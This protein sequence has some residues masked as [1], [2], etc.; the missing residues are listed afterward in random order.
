MKIVHM[1]LSCFFVD[2]YSYQENEI[3][4]TN[5]DDGHE[6][7]VIASTETFGK[8]GK[9][10]YLQPSEY[11]GSEGAKIIR[12]PYKKFLPHFFMR[13][14]RC[15]PRVF[16]ILNDIRPDVILFHGLCGWELITVNKYKKKNSLVKLYVD[17]H[18]DFNN[19]ANGIVS[20]YLLHGI[21]YK[22][23]IHYALGSIEKILCVSQETIEFVR[24]FYRVQHSR[25][26]FY[27]L[28]GIVYSDAEYEKKRN[29]ARKFY[30]IADNDILF[31]QSGKFDSKKRLVDT[32]TAFHKLENKNIKLIIAGV[33]DEDVFNNV[34]KI[35]ENDK[36]VQF[37]GW[38]TS[39]DLNS[40]LCAADV[41]VQ[42][43]SQSATM[44]MSLCARCAVIL[45][46]VTSHIPYMEEN[47]WLI[48]DHFSLEQAIYE[49]SLSQERLR[50]M[51]VNS[52]E[53]SSRL[54]DYKKISSRLYF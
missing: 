40:L 22:C 24:D 12:L 14:L 29:T 7:V 19:S 15:Y 25:L 53:I 10:T 45:D 43:G 2:G 48:S 47:G 35:L 34:H 32:L 21:Y 6:V 16:E 28:G 13:K 26:E 42:P 44:Q 23:L 37:V 3:V 41:Y 5:V 30:T 52:K 8:D 1:C 38:K 49:A 51:S 17:S 9:L 46:N 20:K 11:I 27:P 50:K 33:M 39:E 18:E 31:V 54:L 4:R 36:R